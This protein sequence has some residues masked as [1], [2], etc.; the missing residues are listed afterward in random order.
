MIKPPKP[1]LSAT[2]RA[3][4]RTYFLDVEHDSKGEPFL[5]INESKRIS[6]GKFQRRKIIVAAEHLPNFFLAL[7]SVLVRGRLL[8]PANK[9]K[10]SESIYLIEGKRS[11]GSNRHEPFKEIRE[12]Y[13]NAY[14]YWTADDDRK[15]ED[16]FRS[17][18]EVEVLSETF[19]RK[20]GAITARLRKLGLQD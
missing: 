17:C 8:E 11:D 2:V 16:A 15:L 6:D 12:E 18:Q 1:A 9:R 3:C 5:A 13:P 4:H 10:T 7:Q 14:R 20:P 19:L